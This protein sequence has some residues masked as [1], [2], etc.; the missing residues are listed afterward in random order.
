MTL[1]YRSGLLAIFKFQFVELSTGE[2]YLPL[3]ACYCSLY[4]GVSLWDAMISGVLDPKHCFL[5]IKLEEYSTMPKKRRENFLAN[6]KIGMEI[7]LKV[8]YTV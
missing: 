5:R 6:C 4:R 8:C 3:T 7:P 1:P 2:K